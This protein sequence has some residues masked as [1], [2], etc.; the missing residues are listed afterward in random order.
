MK[1]K[2]RKALTSVLV[3]TLVVTMLPFNSVKASENAISS[4]V[5]WEDVRQEIDGFGASGAFQ[6]PKHLMN[7]PEPQRSE[8]LDLLFSTEKGSGLSIVRN[9]VGDGGIGEWGNEID[10]PSPTIW[11]EEDGGFVW[12]GDE[13]QIWMMNQAKKYGVDKFVST[14]WSP[15]AW[16]KTNNSVKLGGE[17]RE[18]KYQQYADYLSAYIRGYKEHH[19][20]DIYGISLANEPDFNASYSS[21]RWTGAQFSNFIK[22]NLTPTFEKDGINSQV[23]VG[24]GM[25]FQEDPRFVT[26]VLED[27]EA[28]DGV[29]IVAAHA[30]GGDRG[31]FSTFPVTK[32]YDKKLWQTEASNLGTNDPTIKD[33][34]YWA[35]L[36][37]HH[38]TVAETNA[39]FYWWLVSF[40]LDKGEPLINL[41]INNNTYHVNKRLFTIGNYSRFVRPGYSRINTSNT[42]DSGVYVSAYKDEKTGDYAIIAINEN[43]SSTN[44]DLN[45]DGY[46]ASFVTDSVTPYRTSDSEDLAKLD[47]LDVENGTVSTELAGK[48]VTTFVGKAEEVTGSVL[49]PV[50][51]D[52]ASIKQGSKLPVKLELKDSEGNAVTGA[53]PKLFVAEVAD[54][55]AGFEREAVSPGKANKGNVFRYDPE[56]GHYIFN[57]DSKGLSKGTYELRIDIGGHTVNTVQLTVR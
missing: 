37:H 13:D 2:V 17:L 38:M 1:G 16:M 39:W 12:T 25:H 3:S 5:Y 4:T 49:S 52:E 41:D 28:R 26:P 53:A 40:K 19:G 34:L 23:I 50:K 9:M 33:G 44:L 7:F 48:S 42:A 32:K 24:E 10:G 46:N 29:D 15:P 18:D 35:K 8:V 14:V 56:A 55:K 57:F 45:L 22:N 43:D 31:L 51:N 30:Y 11:P 47:E 21:S 6:Q 27:P 54:G 36:L 20:I